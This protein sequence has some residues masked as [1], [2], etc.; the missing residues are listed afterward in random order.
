MKFK[1]VLRRHGVSL[2]IL[3]GAIILFVVIFRKFGPVPGELTP[4]ACEVTQEE[5]ESFDAPEV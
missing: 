5:L 2:A 3:I 4:P 1:K